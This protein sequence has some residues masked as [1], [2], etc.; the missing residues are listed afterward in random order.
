LENLYNHFEQANSF[1]T[2]EKKEKMEKIIRLHFEKLPEGYY[3]AT[4]DDIQGL[5]AQGRTIAE[6]IEIA[7]DIAKKLIEASEGQ[8]AMLPGLSDNFDYPILIGV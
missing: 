7:R 4:S 1:N 2:F 5:V 3:L 6:T 8:I